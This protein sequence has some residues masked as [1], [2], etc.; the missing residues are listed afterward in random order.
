MAKL[1]ID[2]L[3]DALGVEDEPVRKSSR[4]PKE[5]RI[6]AG[7]EDI[8]RF[9]DDHGHMP[10]HGEDK[11]IFE[12]LYA[13]R[14][15]RIRALEDC[16]LLLKDFDR[17]GL[18]A[19]DF[20]PPAASTVIDI[21][22]LL[23]NLGVDDLSEGDITQLKHVK[24]RAE[25]RAAEEIASRTPC[26]DFTIFRPKFEQVQNDLKE[27]IRES[28]RFGED[29]DIAEGE[30]FILGGQTVY[31]DHVGEEF[32]NQYDRKDRRLRVIYSNGTESDILLRSFQRALY[33][34][35][36]GRR[37][38]DPVAGP[39]F[40]S[41]ADATDSES[42]TVYVLRSKSD[43]PLISDNRDVIHKI[44]V[45]GSKIE[46]RIANAKLDAT[47]LMADVEVIATYELFNINRSKL[48]NLIH[49]FFG[50][51][52]FEIEIKDRF[53][54][55]IKPREWFLVPLQAINEAIER[56]Q[57]GSI[58]AYQYDPKEAKLKSLD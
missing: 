42:G 34:D 27:G 8:Q 30:F 18:L 3:L 54:I 10:T 26:K 7:F 39:L 20:K 55:P 44:G 49:R 56:I 21:D 13:V 25:V 48:E 37:I 53:G 40:A 16:H 23:S 50:A 22:A 45:T 4:T 15:D 51:A 41:V 24:P 52:R 1:S 57:D 47:F 32:L 28:R 19:G 46:T 5:E 43:L 58:A 35:E 38:T 31:V 9:V 11:D 14:L 12:R 17:Q 2:A 29:A 6:I 33:K 36:A